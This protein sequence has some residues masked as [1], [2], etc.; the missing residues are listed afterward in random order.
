MLYTILKPKYWSNTN[1]LLWKKHLES[2]T[3]HHIEDFCSPSTEFYEHCF[4]AA[5]AEDYDHVDWG[6]TMLLNDWSYTEKIASQFPGS[7]ILGLTKAPGPDDIKVDAQLLGFDILDKTPAYSCITA[8]YHT[9]EPYGHP[10]INKYALLSQ[11]DTAYKLKSFLKEQFGPQDW[12]A[13]H[14]EVWAVFEV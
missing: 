8:I 14:C 9:P 1:I 6:N 12:H 10:P 2:S 3:L 13:Q 7:R 11:I 5:T 4:L